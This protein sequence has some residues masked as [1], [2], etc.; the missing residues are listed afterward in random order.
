MP[1]KQRPTKRRPRL[2][3][4]VIIVLVI[5]FC[6][7]YAIWAL[8]F[9]DPVAKHMRMESDAVARAFLSHPARPGLEAPGERAGKEE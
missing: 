9:S 4:D 7:I 6:L 3:R 5:K 1:I 8:W 2:A